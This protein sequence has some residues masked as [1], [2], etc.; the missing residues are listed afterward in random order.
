MGERERDGVSLIAS[1]RLPTCSL[2]SC[3]AP[4]SLIP[5]DVKTTL[6]R[7]HQSGRVFSLLEG[8]TAGDVPLPSSVPCP[9]A[10]SPQ[11]QSYT[12]S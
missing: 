9:P 11:R 6:S 2:S 10:K 8:G 3:H 12:G 1:Q 7:G 4:D 5:C